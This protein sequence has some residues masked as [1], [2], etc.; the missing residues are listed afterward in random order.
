MTRWVE[1]NS[2]EQVAEAA[3][4]VIEQQARKAIQQRGE[5]KLVLAGGTTPKSC[6]QIL[7][8]RDL[9]WDRWKLFYGDERCLPVNDDER[10]HR[11]VE[12]TGL[13]G[14]VQHHYIMPAELGSIKGAESYQ[15][16]IQSQLPF[17]LVMLGMGEDGHTA[18][19]FPGQDLHCEDPVHQVIAVHNAPKAPAE[20]IS[21]SCT[22][23]QDCQLML[24]LVTGESK[25]PALQQWLDGERLPLSRVADL[26]YASVF[27]EASLLP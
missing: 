12:A 14:K 24:A 13:A 27:V 20:R 17:D 11:M 4:D 10:N 21:L 3:A 15:A 9:Q 8:R 18:S 26:S 7:A 5:F 23:L 19:L 22:A 6:Y 1:F 25:K 2:A 16:L